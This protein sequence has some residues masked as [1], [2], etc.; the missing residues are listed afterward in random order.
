[1]NVLELSELLQ[2]ACDFNP[3]FNKNENYNTMIL[4]LFI[5]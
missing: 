4:D 5:K 3:S 2:N 1:M